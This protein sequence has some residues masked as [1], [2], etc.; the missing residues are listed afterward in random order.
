MI[1]ARDVEIKIRP[2]LE[3]EKEALEIA[4]KIIVEGYRPKK[5]I[6]KLSFSNIAEAGKL[7]TPKRIELLRLIRR[8]EPE[9][10]YALAKLAGRNVAN[11]GKDVKELK[12]LGLVSVKKGKKRNRNVSRP[13]T[14]F[15]ELKIRIPLAAKTQ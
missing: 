7:L 14:E 2:S 12:Q 8:H 9:S 10:V 5:P 13:S 6:R 15:D 3:W 4:K 1:K 11:V